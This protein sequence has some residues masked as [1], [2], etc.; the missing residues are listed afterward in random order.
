MKNVNTIQVVSESTARNVVS[1]EAA[2]ERAVAKFLDEKNGE[3]EG[4]EL[5]GTILDQRGCGRTLVVISWMPT[6]KKKK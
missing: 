2:V 1:L 4:Y 3:L 5:S 6:E